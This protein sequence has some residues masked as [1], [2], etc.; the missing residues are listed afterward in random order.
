MSKQVWRLS[1]ALFILFVTWKDIISSAE[2]SDYQRTTQ[3]Q[4]RVI[5]DRRYC[6]VV[7]H[8]LRGSN[9]LAVHNSVIR[10]HR[11]RYVRS[12]AATTLA[13]HFRHWQDASRVARS[14][15]ITSHILVTTK[16]FTKKKIKTQYYATL[17]G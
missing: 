8:R 17:K 14:N 4:S 7:W 12:L 16:C 13:V 2:V 1:T 6:G 11:Q 10:R 5:G 3:K 15:I 9:V